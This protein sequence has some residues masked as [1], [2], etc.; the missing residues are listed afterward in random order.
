MAGVKKMIVSLWKIPDRETAELMTSF[1]N[2]WIK[3]KTINDAFT[4]AQADMRKKYPPFYWA[5]FVLVE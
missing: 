5:A 3:G 4:Q 1:Y 2:Y